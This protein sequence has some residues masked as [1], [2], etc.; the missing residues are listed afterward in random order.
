MP[1]DFLIIGLFHPL[2]IKIVIEP[3][4][5]PVSNPKGWRT[6]VATRPHRLLQD[7]LLPVSLRNKALDLLPLGDGH[8]P[9][10]F[11]QLPSGILI[12]TPDLCVDNLLDFH[13]LF[14]KKL[15]GIVTGRSTLAQICPVDDHD[16][17]LLVRNDNKK[18]AQFYEVNR[19]E[20]HF[21]L[22]IKG[23]PVSGLCGKSHRPSIAGDDAFDRNA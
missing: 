7:R 1:K 16:R 2:F 21:S 8:C 20:R 23:I 19:R 14:P 17:L 10:G 6:Q 12:E 5:E 4:D 3:D 9:G 11:Q 15:L 22:Q 18:I 13:L